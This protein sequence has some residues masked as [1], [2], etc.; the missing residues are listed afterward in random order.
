[1]PIIAI[2]RKRRQK[3]TPAQLND[4]AQDNHMQPNPEHE[5][6][7]RSHERNDLDF[8]DKFKG[9]LPGIEFDEPAELHEA[10]IAVVEAL[11]ENN[12]DLL[13]IAWGEY[14]DVCEQIVDSEAPSDSAVHIRA[15]LQIAILVHKALIFREVENMQRCREELLDVRMYAYN[16]HRNEIV[17]A[18][19]AELNNLTTEK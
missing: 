7:P 5:L 8:S 11:T 10:R 16:V 9:L 2:E 15:G 19:N 17:K 14:I 1:M 6:T 13:S 3:H 4:L 18:I 12:S